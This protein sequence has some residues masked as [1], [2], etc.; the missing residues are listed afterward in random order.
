[1]QHDWVLDVLADLQAFARA[2]G[3]ADLDAQLALAR[4]S[5]R[6]EIASMDE[7]TH[8]G[9]P[10]GKPNGAGRAAGGPGGLRRP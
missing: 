2:N 7:G 3:L 5:A 4:L 1:M 10:G 8:V 9:T 6:A